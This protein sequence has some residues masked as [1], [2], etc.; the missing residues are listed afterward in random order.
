MF[1]LACNVFEWILAPATNL[2]IW[3]SIHKSAKV[4]MAVLNAYFVYVNVYTYR[5]GYKT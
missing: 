5:R 1:K 3:R 4:K 2:L